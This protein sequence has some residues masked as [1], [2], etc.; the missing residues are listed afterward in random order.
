M[1]E[2]RRILRLDGIFELLL[3]SMILVPAASGADMEAAFG[4]NEWAVV[5][6]GIAL[7]PVGALLLL[8]KPDRPTL[9]ALGVANAAGAGVF[10]I[11][12][13]AR[14]AE[15]NAYGIIVLVAAIAGLVALAVAEMRLGIDRRG[16]VPGPGG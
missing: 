13:V 16:T 15:M 4:L 14:A 2:G 6:I 7:V 1:L 12:L 5:G 11:Y 9:L 10:A 8:A 3:A